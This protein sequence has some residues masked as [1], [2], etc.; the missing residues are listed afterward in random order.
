M[1]KLALTKRWSNALHIITSWENDDEGQDD[2]GKKLEG[3]EEE[4][5]EIVTMILMV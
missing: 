4:E 1:K 5:D 3:K 2:E